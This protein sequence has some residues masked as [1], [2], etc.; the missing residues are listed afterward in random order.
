MAVPLSATM[1]DSASVPPARDIMIQEE[2]PVAEAVALFKKQFGE[3]PT[4]GA[5][6]PGR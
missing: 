2:D 3:A 6:A 1:S 4:I 5:A